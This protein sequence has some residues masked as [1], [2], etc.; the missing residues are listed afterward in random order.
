VLIEEE[1]EED[2]TLIFQPVVYL[3]VT[4]YGLSKGKEINFP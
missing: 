3:G 4:P 1:E 2:Y